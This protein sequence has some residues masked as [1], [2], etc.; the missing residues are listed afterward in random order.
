MPL[1]VEVNSDGQLGTIAYG[2]VPTRLYCKILQN[3]KCS[4]SN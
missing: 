1:I 4:H 2:L 3:E